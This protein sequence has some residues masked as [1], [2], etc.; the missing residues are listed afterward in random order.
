MVM[1]VLD[2]DG[3][4]RR[5]GRVVVCCE[6]GGRMEARLG[7]GDDGQARKRAGSNSRWRR[8]RRRAGNSVVRPVVEVA[9]E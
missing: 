1:A 3:G 7:T 4:E 8:F 2:V 9:W 6:D 5:R